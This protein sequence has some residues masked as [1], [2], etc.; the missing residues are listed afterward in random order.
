MLSKMLRGN[1]SSGSEDDDSDTGSKVTMMVM[2]TALTMRMM[3]TTEAVI[4]TMMMVVA[5]TIAMFCGGLSMCPAWCQV[6][7]MG[8]FLPLLRPPQ[9]CNPHFAERE[10]EASNSLAKATQLAKLH[11]AKI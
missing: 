10:I 7:Y 2:M 11:R 5:V 9:V 6:L 4:L 3:T 8:C 1:T